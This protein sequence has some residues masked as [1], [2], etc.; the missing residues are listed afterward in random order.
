MRQKDA[1]VTKGANTMFKIF[2]G[3]SFI[4]VLATPMVVNSN[5]KAD[6]EEK[7]I[8]SVHRYDEYERTR[9]RT[10]KVNILPPPPPPT[11]EELFPLESLPAD[12][13]CKEWFHTS[14]HAGWTLDEW[15]KLGKIIF[16]ESRCLPNACGE[17][18]SPHVRKCRDWGLLQI[19]DYSWKTTIR[20]MGMSIEQMHDP[21]WNLWFGRWLFLYSLD[22]NDDG[23]QPWTPSKW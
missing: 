22:R 18:D 5:E 23:W 9:L 13:P 4:P 20:N 12:W 21:Y 6:Q 16:R 10:V 15:P 19:N 17:T 3:L 8:E 7:A 2:I 11:I 14:L 1:K